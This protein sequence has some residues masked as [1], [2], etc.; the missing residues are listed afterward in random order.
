LFAKMRGGQGSIGGGGVDRLLCRLLGEFREQLE[1]G[2]RGLEELD[3]GAVSK[4]SLAV[5]A[6]RNERPDHLPAEADLPAGSPQFHLAYA[7]R[8]ERA[9]VFDEETERADVHCLQGRDLAEA[10]LQAFLWP[11]ALAAPALPARCGR[12]AGNDREPSQ[13]DIGKCHGTHRAGSPGMR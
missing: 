7:P 6:I 9:L 2:G 8:P 4:A 12:R 3:G 10:D 1:D 13:L 5:S 11:D